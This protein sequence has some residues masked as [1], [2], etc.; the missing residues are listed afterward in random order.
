MVLVIVGAA[1]CS[2]YSPP[3]AV[4]LLFSKIRLLRVG[5]PSAMVI[6]PPALLAPDVALEFPLEI[7]NPSKMAVLVTELAVTT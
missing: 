7:A 2:R 1:P 5:L 6:P 4:A 3:A